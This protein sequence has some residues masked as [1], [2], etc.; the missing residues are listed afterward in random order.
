MTGRLLAVA[1]LAL[2]APAS[3]YADD[4]DRLAAAL[5]DDPV[6][7]APS[8]RARL[9]PAAAGQVRLRIAGK[10]VGRIK[11]AV[12]SSA[13]TRRSGG[14]D[15]LANAVAARLQRPGTLVLVAGPHWWLNTSFPPGG[16]VA[17]VREATAKEHGLRR[18]LLAAVDGIAAADPGP[19]ADPV[20]AGGSV[21]G[22][23]SAPPPQTVTILGF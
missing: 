17:A 12:V 9:S 19:R 1:A 18:Q 6:H 10:D 20:D 21:P 15:A 7:V 2:V 5:K 22:T 11:V 14:L 4:A 16:V 8:Q 23:G 3:A 13:A